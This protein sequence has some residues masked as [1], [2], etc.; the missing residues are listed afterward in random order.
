[1]GNDNNYMIYELSNDD[2][3]KFFIYNEIKKLNKNNISNINYISDIFHKIEN[4]YKK[5]LHERYKMFRV[6]IDDYKLSKDELNK[7][8]LYSMIKKGTDCNQYYSLFLTTLI[9]KLSKEEKHIKDIKIQ[10]MVA[11]INE[12]FLYTK[13]LKK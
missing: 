3:G 8:F 2:I 6:N 7:I 12:S 11:I 4:E 13:I 10:D 5:I 9:Q 1:M